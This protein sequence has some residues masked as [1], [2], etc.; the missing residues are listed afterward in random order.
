MNLSATDHDRRPTRPEPGRPARTRSAWGLLLVPLLSL[1][2]L[3]SACGG[4]DDDS[5]GDSGSGGDDSATP[6]P[7]GEIAYGL[8]AETSGGWCLP[9]S[10]LAISGIQVARTIYDT[11][12]APN[13]DGEIVP[14][15]AESVEPNADSTE[16]TIKLREGVKFHD[17]SDLTAE[18]VKNNLDAY[19]GEY[20]ARQ[21]LLFRFVFEDVA[22][23]DVVDDLTVKV[24]TSVPW[25]AF[26]WA[27][28]G[29]G[30][31]GMVA[32]AQLD[33]P[34]TCD[35]NLIG[36]GPFKLVEWVQN[37]S[38]VAEK[39]PDYWQTDQDGNQLPYLDRITY[40]P[41]IDETARVNALDSNDVQAIMTNDGTAIEQIKFGAEEGRLAAVQTDQLSE[42]SFV[43]F[44]VSKPP[45]DNPLARRA[46]A[47]A[48]DVEQYIQTIGIGQFEAASGPFAKGVIGYL[49]DAGFPAYDPD[50]AAE[51]AAQYE[52][53]TGQPLEFNLSG[54]NSDGTVRALSFLQDQLKQAGIQAEVVP[55]EQAAL[56]STAL[57][58]DWQAMLFRNY[59]GADPDTQYNWWY[60][61][62]PV[63]FGQMADPE[64]D[65][66]L[67]AGRES[68]DQ[69]ERVTI[70]EDL[71]R[72]FGSEVYQSW[73]NWSNWTIGTSADV[74]GVLG[75]L[76]PD[77]SEPSPGL[78][79][80]NP[81]SGMWLAQ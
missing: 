59:P 11:L 28:Y 49:E 25:P 33:D 27:L 38:L 15:L 40:R 19:R 43:N 61:G 1:A 32:Q 73:L 57:G 31:I 79:P 56:I 63:N 37:D 55:I 81:V 44:N 26:P 4:G 65:A 35:T 47:S 17:G 76:L 45:F 80:G 7:G 71:N 10:Q 24:T 14:F 21:P 8:E 72:R 3:A 52:Q 75:P 48:I 6:V 53:E 23:V 5:G 64:V 77:G 69:D 51:L 18:V 39:N 42:V 50:A 9:E 34:D 36:T 74:K 78:A 66:L 20:P 2:M 13:A 68:S 70:Y 29:T 46:V 12:T 30:R 16:F 58:G 41:I 60:S 67:D 62:S 22:S 54:A